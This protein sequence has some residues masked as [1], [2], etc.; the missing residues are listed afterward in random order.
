[1]RSNIGR[2]NKPA[3]DPSEIHFFQ[4]DRVFAARPNASILNSAS[5]SFDVITTQLISRLL[6]SSHIV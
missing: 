6:T 2:P 5:P 3:G 1:M 4:C